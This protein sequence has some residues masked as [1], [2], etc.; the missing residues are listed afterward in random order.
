MPMYEYRCQQC[1][2]QFEVIQKFSDEPLTTHAEC[3][4]PVERLLSAPALQ[5][6]GSGWYITDYARSGSSGGGKNGKSESS[7]ESKSDSSKSETKTSD[8]KPAATSSDSKS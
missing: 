8:S 7:S 3:G 5:F 6:K 4:G 1:G 2:K